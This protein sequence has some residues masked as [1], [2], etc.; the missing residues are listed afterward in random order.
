MFGAGGGFG[1]GGR[2]FG[3]DRRN[4][5]RVGVRFDGGGGAAMDSWLSGWIVGHNRCL[6][7]VIIN[8]LN[9]ITS[10]T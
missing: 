5:S 3:G 9:T 4:P 2:G 8:S 1:G 6:P 10:W 7:L